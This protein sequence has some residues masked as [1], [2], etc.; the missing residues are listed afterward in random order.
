MFH[1]LYDLRPILCMKLYDFD[2]LN[3]HLA[4]MHYDSVTHSPHLIFTISSM[5]AS[6]GPL[7]CLTT[8]LPFSRTPPSH[9]GVRGSYRRPLP[10]AASAGRMP[11]P[12]SRVGGRR[13]EDAEAQCTDQL[14]RWYKRRLE[15]RARWNRLWKAQKA[16]LKRRVPAELA[17]L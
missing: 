3:T 2:V 11:S 14:R 16:A 1:S 9:N 7:V 12:W 4:Y 17:T 10:P 13:C 6:G 8:S 5:E 15:I